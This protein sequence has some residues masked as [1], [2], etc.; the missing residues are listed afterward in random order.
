MKVKF[1]PNTAEIKDLNLGPREIA[2]PVVSQRLPADEH[3]TDITFIPGWPFWEVSADKGM[4]E[5]AGWRQS[6]D[7]L[8][9]GLTPEYGRLAG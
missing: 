3:F 8:E 5:G 9:L 4:G 7:L 6:K 1:G 2:E